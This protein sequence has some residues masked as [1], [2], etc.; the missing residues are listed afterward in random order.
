LRSESFPHH[1]PDGVSFPV[2]AKSL[3]NEVILKYARREAIF[4]MGLWLA[5]FLY[6]VIYCYWFGYLKHPPLNFLGIQLDFSR[7]DRSPSDL[8][9]IY[10]I[11]DWVVWGVG[12]PWLVCLVLT[13]WFSLAF[14]KDEELGEDREAELA[15]RIHEEAHAE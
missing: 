5:S 9:L 3:R 13:V 10:G 1:R 7:L 15:E 8:K 11:P 12:L 6:T 4:V 2:G 14:M